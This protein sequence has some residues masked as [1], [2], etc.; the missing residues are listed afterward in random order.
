[1]APKTLVRV[2]DFVHLASSLKP[3]E[4]SYFLDMEVQLDC[5]FRVERLGRGGDPNS[6]WGQGVFLTC[7]CP[8]H[9]NLIDPMVSGTYILD[10]TT[11][12]AYLHEIK[13]FWPIRKT[14]KFNPTKRQKPNTGAASRIHRKGK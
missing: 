8:I 9:G 4:T 7:C 14:N 6:S 13:P 3:E 11:L 2:G 5:L 10:K 12:F 1:M